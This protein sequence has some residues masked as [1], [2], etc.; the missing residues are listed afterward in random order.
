MNHLA[1]RIKSQPTISTCGPT[2][3]HSI[4]AFYGDKIPLDQLISEIPELTGGGTLGV[5]LG[6]HALARGYDVTIYSHNLRVFDPTWFELSKT[7]QIDKLESQIK[8]KKHKTK[9]VQVS[10]HYQ[11][12]LL[13]GGDIKFE[14]ISPRFLNAFLKQKQPVLTGLSATYLYKSAREYGDDCV[15]DDVKGEPQGHFV[16]ISGMVDEGSR[17]FIADPHE[18]NPVGGGKHYDVDTFDLISAILIGV[19][20]YDANIIIIKKK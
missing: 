6:S 1:I 11:N 5:Q 4:Y 13:N 7:Q 17:V 16:V 8:A 9:L 14:S 15:Y 10:R 2:C 19:I 3:L 18:H 20:T 12:F